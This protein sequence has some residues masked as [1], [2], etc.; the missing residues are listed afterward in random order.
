M[1]RNRMDVIC[2]V[3]LEAFQKLKPDIMAL[4]E[5]ETRGVI[6]T[7]QSDGDYDFQS[8]FFGPRV[9]VDED[10]VTGSAHCCL[11]P[12][13]AEKLARGDAEMRAYQASPRGGVL[14]VRVASG[15]VFIGGFAVTSSKG[16]LM[17]N[18]ERFFDSKK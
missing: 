12:F 10:P 5:I 6:V 15:R 18:P 8:R 1:G 4:K 9:G 3:S 2:E 13:W 7:C 11:A 16:R 17:S 14:A